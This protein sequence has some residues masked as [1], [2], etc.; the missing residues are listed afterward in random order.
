MISFSLPRPRRLLLLGVLALS[1]AG[2][3]VTHLVRRP[4]DRPAASLP[5]DRAAQKLDT[6]C[7]EDLR[8]SHSAC[9]ELF[10]DVPCEALLP[11][12]WAEPGQGFV[13]LALAQVGALDSRYY[14]LVMARESTRGR[15][16]AFVFATLLGLDGRVLNS[17]QPF[18]VGHSP[19]FSASVATVATL[20]T[21]VLSLTIG[22]FGERQAVETF[23]LDNGSAR[24]LRFEYA[25]GGLIAN[26]YES[27]WLTVGP[28]PDGLPADEA[29]RRLLHGSRV[30]ILGLLTVIYGR[31][32]SVPYP[33]GFDFPS[34]ERP[35]L[36][37][38]FAAYLENMRI[39]KRIESLAASE[40][41][42]IREAA[43]AALLNFRP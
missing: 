17:T 35:H 1:L 2:L 41:P 26:S 3:V 31:H 28:L 29:E 37:A 33:S 5:A 27:P 9:R 20:N 38:C 16:P 6:L 18:L 10:R 12:P 36:A 32:R 7:G 14:C 23:A 30:E 11:A 22:H 34:V 43:L 25:G 21:T 8:T 24:L 40:D 15:E 19:I 39:K 13:P 42:W 4:P